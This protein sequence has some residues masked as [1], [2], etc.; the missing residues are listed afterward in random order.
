[1]TVATGNVCYTKVG[2]CFSIRDERLH[3]VVEL[4]SNQTVE[5]E[6]TELTAHFKY[7]K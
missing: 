6:L 1:M 5:I 3:S 4:E 2:F 7:S